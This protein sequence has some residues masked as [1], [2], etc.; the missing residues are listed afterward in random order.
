MNAALADLADAFNAWALA[1]GG[2]AALLALLLLALDPGVRRLPAAVQHA[3][4][5]LVPLR[6]LLPPT[7]GSPL[8]WSAESLP[9]DAAAP[10]GAGPAAPWPLLVSVVGTLALLALGA[11]ARRRWWSSLHAGAC[12]APRAL[13]ALV[14]EASARRG[15]SR[16]PRVL[17]TRAI[18]S[19][20]VA[21]VLRP[22]LI[23]PATLATG[24]G[25]L[26]EHALA[27]E[28]A[29]LSR[30]DLWT[31]ALFALAQ[32]LAW[33]HPA[34]FVARRRARALRELLCDA[35]VARGLGADG[36][37]DYRDALLDLALA[38]PRTSAP[39]HAASLLPPSPGILARLAALEAL[40]RPRR[41]AAGLAWL[42]PLVAAGVLLPATASLPSRTDERAR[43]TEALE[44]L[45]Q[46]PE[47]PGCLRLRFAVARLVAADHGS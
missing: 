22:T 4:W 32:H 11:R 25:R 43:A 9:L 44:A 42:A 18:T 7:V 31:E 27:H 15:L 41:R 21:G 13:L 16:P 24:P 5:L 29:H 14:A 39:G 34:A 2:Q 12:A 23:L 8:A 45:L 30:R 47:R 20:C 36:T 35:T 1:A 46:G 6:L 10:A 17:V 19:P 40:A 33:W 37:R 26:L 38:A 3:L 28:L